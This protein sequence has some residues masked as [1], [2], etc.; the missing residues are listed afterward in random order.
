MWRFYPKSFPMLILAGFSLAVVPL[1]FAL[2]NNAVS[3]RELATKSQRAVFNAVQATQSSRQFIE[4]I[5]SMERSVRQFSILADPQIFSVFEASHREFLD[6]VRRMRALPL[7]PA[8]QRVLDRM[9]EIENLLFTSVAG[10]RNQPRL[11]A[12]LVDDYVS[13]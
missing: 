10:L 4:Q 3:I 7:L 11:V 12:D 8:Q 6:T 13:L 9:S 2:I 5:T 1:I